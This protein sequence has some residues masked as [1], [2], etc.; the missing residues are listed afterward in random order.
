MEVEEA[1]RI[2]LL[3]AD[4]ET[5]RKEAKS[6]VL[7]SSTTNRWSKKGLF[8]T[9]YANLRPNFDKFFLF[10]QMSISSSDELTLHLKNTAT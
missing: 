6:C 4:T 8:V 7:D 5:Q 10:T 1:L 9:F 2:C 3:A